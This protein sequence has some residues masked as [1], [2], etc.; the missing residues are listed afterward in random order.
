MQGWGSFF[1][2]D[3]LGS[4]LSVSFYGFSLLVYSGIERIWVLLCR[5]LILLVELKYSCDL[6]NST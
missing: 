1:Q 2:F 5:F 6:W 3:S 4:L